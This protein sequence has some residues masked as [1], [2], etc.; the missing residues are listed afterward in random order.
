[1][2]FL[3]DD[4][5]AYGWLR[6]AYGDDEAERAAALPVEVWKGLYSELFTYGPGFREVQLFFA[7]AEAT[8][9]P[10][11]LQ[12][13]LLPLW[14]LDRSRPS[15][16]KMRALDD[17]QG[18]LALAS[19]PNATATELQYLIHTLDL[20][21]WRVRDAQGRHLNAWHI[22]LVALLLTARHY[23]DVMGHYL[24]FAHEANPAFELLGLHGLMF[25]DVSVAHD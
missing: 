9:D 16:E 20:H 25:A 7:A 2:T 6:A 4:G 11:G 24:S 5:M 19:D 14:N 12:G 15:D 10:A 17:I 13:C 8:D 22:L 18:T 1:M 3:L 21:S 23:P